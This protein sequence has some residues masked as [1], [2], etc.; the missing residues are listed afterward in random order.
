MSMI[1]EQ[2]REYSDYGGKSKK[3]KLGGINRASE[4]T[5]STNPNIHKRINADPESSSD[6][7]V[8]EEQA[9]DKGQ[10]SLE[11]EDLDN[12]QSKQ[13]TNTKQNKGFQESKL[14]SDDGKPQVR[15]DEREAEDNSTDS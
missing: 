9:N 1:K 5:T 4:V 15:Q 11:T 14:V 7:I 13:K 12:N 10:D 3:H 8:S 6:D 2:S